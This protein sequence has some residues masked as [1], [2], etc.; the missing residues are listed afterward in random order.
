MSTAAS[1]RHN[2]LKQRI[3]VG[4]V[5]VGKKNAHKED[6][7]N[8]E[9]MTESAPSAGRL[10]AFTIDAGTAQIVKLETLD[11]SGARRELSEEEKASLAQAGAEEGLEQ[12]VEKAFEAGIACVLG[13]DEQQ[14]KS[15]EA[16]EEAELRRLLLKPLIE[17]SPVRR[18]MQREALNR[19]IL[20]TLLQRAV[21]KAPVDAE[22]APA[23][24][25]QPDRAASAHAN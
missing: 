20:G 10:F 24:G 9:K 16:A 21:S 18:L 1:P 22:S 15:T 6:K 11:A 17:H 3:P 8:E 2:H 12:F 13:D 4:K 14:H 25:P 23:A 7:M 19:A 5:P